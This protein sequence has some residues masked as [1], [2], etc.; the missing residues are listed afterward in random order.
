MSKNKYKIFEPKYTQ[1]QKE[2]LHS[3]GPNMQSNRFLKDKIADSGFDVLWLISMDYNLRD[4]IVKC[5]M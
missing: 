1:R 3:G 2:F 4:L 5:E